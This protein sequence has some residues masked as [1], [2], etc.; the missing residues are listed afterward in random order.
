VGT[1]LTHPLRQARPDQPP[2]SRG[3]IDV[4]EEVAAKSDVPVV[5]NGSESVL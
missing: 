1:A 4:I 2:P 5:E 3:V